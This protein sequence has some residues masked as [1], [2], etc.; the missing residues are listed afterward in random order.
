[1]PWIRGE[2]A[3][4]TGDQGFRFHSGN[5]IDIAGCIVAGRALKEPAFPLQARVAHLEL[6]A[7]QIGGGVALSFCMI[8]V[9]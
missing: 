6:V 9:R 4:I 5:K 3:L 7:H 1:M 8:W 2:D